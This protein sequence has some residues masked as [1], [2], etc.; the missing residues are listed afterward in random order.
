MTLE[1]RQ[2]ALDD[3]DALILIDE[4][5][6]HLW[7]QYPED[8]ATYAAGNVLP[9]GTTL[10]VAYLDGKA[11]G[12]GAFKPFDGERVEIKRMYTRSGLRG[13]GIATAILQKLEQ[14]ATTAGFV[15]TVLETGSR[16]VEA[17]RLYE[18]RGYQRRDC[19]GMYADM[20]LSICYEKVL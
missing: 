6:Y 7:Q 12:C 13:Q 2:V 10:M 14:M 8:Q 15:K 3:A 17:M 16:Q 5:N 4:L 11:V 19:Y 1:V 20:P 18:K 9:D